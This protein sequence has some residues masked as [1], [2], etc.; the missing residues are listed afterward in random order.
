MHDCSCGLYKTECHLLHSPTLAPPCGV[1]RPCALLHPA[2]SV[3]PAAQLPAA[4]HAAAEVVRS[5]VDYHAYTALPYIERCS[6]NAYWGLPMYAAP[7]INSAPLIVQEPRE[8]GVELMAERF[9]GFMDMYEFIAM[10]PFPFWTVFAMACR[11]KHRRLTLKDNV[12]QSQAIKA[13]IL[14]HL[15]K[16]P[17][18]KEDS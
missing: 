4:F 11:N 15:M 5:H 14:Q 10:R 12:Q 13:D 18:L 3:Q 6:T 16:R 2:A 9:T 17:Q 8:P 1:C 7:P